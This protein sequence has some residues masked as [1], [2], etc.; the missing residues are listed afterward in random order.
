MSGA[1][2]WIG[3]KRFPRLLAPPDADQEAEQPEN[4]D[5]VDHRAYLL[6][7]RSE[8]V[9]QVGPE[10]VDCEGCDTQSEVASDE[11]PDDNQDERE[12][13]LLHGDTQN[14]SIDEEGDGNYDAR[15]RLECR[16]QETREALRRCTRRG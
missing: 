15:I 5:A 11:K 8:D 16:G 1:L 7:L 14:H 2:V 12:N 13:P 6:H 9:G 3:D 10:V 4:G